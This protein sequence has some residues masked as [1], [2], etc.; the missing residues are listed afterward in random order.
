[1]LV[2]KEYLTTIYRFFQII[3]TSKLDGEHAEGPV[4]DSC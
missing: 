4:A 1:M 2:E 3:V